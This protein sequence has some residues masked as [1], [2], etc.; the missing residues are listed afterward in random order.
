MVLMDVLVAGETRC[1]S[2]A[3]SVEDTSHSSGRLVVS[4]FTR[5]L[6]SCF[7]YLFAHKLRIGVQS[8]DT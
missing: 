7:L 5:T 2:T 8:Q 3:E 1:R 4:A 6:V